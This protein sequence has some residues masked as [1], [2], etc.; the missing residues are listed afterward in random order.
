V[1]FDHEVTEVFERL[2]GAP[3]RDFLPSYQAAQDLRHFDI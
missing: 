1:T 3:Q 2:L